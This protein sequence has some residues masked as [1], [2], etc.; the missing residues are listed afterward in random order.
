MTIE[1]V[2]GGKTGG[3]SADDDDVRATGRSQERLTVGDTGVGS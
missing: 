1:F 3:A 2:D